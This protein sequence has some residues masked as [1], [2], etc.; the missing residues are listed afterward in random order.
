MVGSQVEEQFVEVSGGGRCGEFRRGPRERLPLA[1]RLPEVDFDVM[2][3]F[4]G[5]PLGGG[6]RMG[7]E[8]MAGLHEAGPKLCVLGCGVCSQVAFDA[9]EASRS[10]GEFHGID[11]AGKGIEPQ[12]RMAA[13]GFGEDI[14]EQ[15]RE[16]PFDF[17]ARGGNGVAGGDQEEGREGNGGVAGE[18]GR[19]WTLTGLGAFGGNVGSLCGGCKPARGRKAQV[20]P[21]R[22]F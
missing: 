8:E 10:S 2:A 4:H 6:L 1:V 7:E 13:D 17:R 12:P 20:V 14:A 16:E 22:N 15:H 9:G 21:C 5:N 3:G 18:H 11:G 19:K